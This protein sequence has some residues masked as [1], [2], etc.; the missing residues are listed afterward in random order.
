LRIIRQEGPVLP[1]QFAKELKT[2]I[3]FA[4]AMLSELVS[5]K[6][7]KVSGVKVGGSPL[8]YLPEHVDKLQG[9]SKY[10]PGKEQEAYKILK[11]KKVL[12]DLDQEPAIRVALSNMKDYAWP[13]NAKINSHTELFWKW[14]LI[15]NDEATN[16]IRG[17]LGL[18]EVK[19]VKKE[20]VEEKPKVQKVE[21][22]PVKKEEPKKAEEK[23]EIVKKETPKI[24]E[25]KV[26]EDNK[27]ESK[28]EE[29]KES[30]KAEG[31]KLTTPKTNIEPSDDFLM[32]IVDYFRQNNINVLNK[33]I[34]KKNSDIDFVVEMSSVV[35]TLRYYCKAKSK[36]R[37]GDGDLSS[38]FV[39]GQLR[40]LPVIFLTYGEPTKKAKEML[41]KEFQNIV[42]KKI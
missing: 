35:G 13:L 6:L 31:P 10:L 20:I 19:P 11:E 28:I 29:N 22:K 23:K 36:K 14:Y 8:Y 33:E 16:I 41:G 42:F 27:E 40:K 37:V 32:Q 26:E 1:V 39:Q 4:S 25:K 9:F 34:I 7:L 21:E 15:E 30:I 38:A 24:E 3:L 2:S 17:M 12:K 18:K 5:A